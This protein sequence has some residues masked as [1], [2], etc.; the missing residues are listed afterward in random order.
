MSNYYYNLKEDS[1]VRYIVSIDYEYLK[2]LRKQIIDNCSIIEH[3]HYKTTKQPKY[4]SD[5]HIRNY[6]SEELGIKSYND[7]YSQDEM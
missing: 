4:F 3:K 7:V 5:E 6:H 1:I 2:E